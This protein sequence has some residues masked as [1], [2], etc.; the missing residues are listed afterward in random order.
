MKMKNSKILSLF[1]AF[2]LMFSMTYGATSKVKAA[3]TMQTLTQAMLNNLSGKLT[4]P[5]DVIY[6]LTEDIVINNDLTI[7]TQDGNFGVIELNG[8]KITVASGKKLSV[9]QNVHFNSQDNPV[10]D[11]ESGAFAV[12]GDLAMNQAI[13][14]VPYDK[15]IEIK[16]NGTSEINASVIS[17]NLT[18]ILSDGQCTIKGMTKLNLADTAKSIGIKVG[19]SGKAVIINY[20]EINAVN[21]FDNSSGG[22]MY[23]FYSLVSGSPVPGAYVSG[24]NISLNYDSSKALDAAASDIKY[25]LDGTEPNLN[26]TTELNS[27]SPAASF[28]FNDT[29]VVKMLAVID[30]QSYQLDPLVYNKGVSTEADFLT[31][32]NNIKVTGGDIYL[33]DNIFIFDTVELTAEK[34]VHIYTGPN[35]LVVSEDENNNIGKLT[36]GNNI[37]IEGFGIKKAGATYSSVITVVNSAQ[38]YIN[39]GSSIKASD[40]NGVAITVVGDG[41]VIMTGGDVYAVKTGIAVINDNNSETQTSLNMTGGHIQVTAQQSDGISA[42]CGGI[43]TVAGTSSIT[44]FGNQSTG[45]CAWDHANVLIKGNAVINTENDQGMAVTSD[46]FSVVTLDESCTLNANGNGGTAVVSHEDGTVN[47]LNG[48]LNANGN[49]CTAFAVDGFKEGSYTDAIAN[50][51]GGKINVI[52]QGGLG[53][54]CR[55]DAHTKI[56]ANAEIEA[57]GDNTIAVFSENSGEVILR[58]TA[59]IGADGANSI[60]IYSSNGNIIVNDSPVINA[61]GNTGIGAKSEDGGKMD[62]EGS[63]VINANGDNGTGLVSGT[64]GNLNIQGGTINAKANGLKVSTVDKTYGSMLTL[65]SSVIVNVADDDGLGIIVR[66]EGAVAKIGDLTINAPKEETVNIG[67][68]IASIPLEQNI[69]YTPNN[70]GINWITYGYDGTNIG[71]YEVFGIGLWP[72]GF[73]INKN[74]YLYKTINVKYAEDVNQD[75]SVDVKDLALTAQYYNLKSSAANWNSTFDINGDNIIDIYDLVRIARKMQ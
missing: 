55:N 1:L 29:M 24:T 8:Y 61:N 4:I 68:P 30:G 9:A 63:P 23:N 59:K 2:S 40:A 56:F 54:C 11:N 75:G 57:V 48:T 52:G 74:I 42:I 14:D 67:I 73:N 72:S 43:V 36:I 50:M 69:P 65:S 45:I 66:G 32:F 21:S 53:V 41:K 31:N 15:A 38:L 62:I 70:I 3:F 13:M 49:Y 37:D 5:A 46:H 27:S 22:K 19:A 64:H 25:T 7:E 10:R 6:K 39:D 12:Y 51:S 28:T 20:S 26:T 18:G 60:A 33:A 35:K 47:F 17:C 71:K 16:A 44:A 34:P 58:G